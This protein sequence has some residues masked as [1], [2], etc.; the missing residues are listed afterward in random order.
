MGWLMLLMAIVAL[1]VTVVVRN[2][3]L[4]QVDS[5]VAQALH[6]EAREFSGVAESGVDR[7]TGEP[8]ESVHDLLFNHLERQYADDDEVLVGWNGRQVLHQ[9]HEVPF[10]LHARF[11]VL[12]PILA[13]PENTGSVETDAGEMR[14]VKVPVIGPGDIPENAD[15]GVFVVAYFVDRDRD[16]VAR[17]INTL[18]LVSLLGLLLAGIAAW[19]VSGQILAPVRLLHQTAATITE[20]DLSR[21]IPVDGNSANDDIAALATQFNAMLDRLEHAFAAQRQFVDD[22][23]HELRTPITI[24]R[25]NLE[26]MDSVTSDPGERAEVIRLCTD[27]LDR[28]NRIVADLLV[29]A[30]S[31]RPDFV[32]PEAVELTELTSDLFAKIH[33]LG[34]RNWRLEAI[35]EG[36]VRLDE[37]RVT[38]AVLQLAHNAV[39]HTRAGDE[40][41]LGTAVLDGAVSFWITDTGPGVHPRDAAKIF[42]RFGRG[43]GGSDARTGAGLGLAIVKAIAEAHGGTVHLVSVPGEGA[44]FG[45]ELPVAGGEDR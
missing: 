4:Q 13:A 9:P 42:E 39:T 35:G 7:A 15:R 34:A 11:D 41:R 23:S 17:T 31:E 18:M 43:S 36:T 37:Q 29:L 1:T 12:Q 40:I 33:A 44:T 24:V 28:M 25:G 3:L 26:L 5:Q 6:Q 19:M 2:L 45:I 32:R 14:W 38:Q 16:E 21:R 20:Q 30:T 22:A 8:F 27:E 10:P